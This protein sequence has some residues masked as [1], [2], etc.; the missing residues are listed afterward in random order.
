L[1]LHHNGKATPAQVREAVARILRDVERMFGIGLTPEV[2]TPG[3]DRPNETP[4]AG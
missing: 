1:V 4:F 3:F 2:V